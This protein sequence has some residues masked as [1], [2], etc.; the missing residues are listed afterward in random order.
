MSIMSNSS[1]PSFLVNVDFC[2]TCHGTCKGCLLT[3]S[4]RKATEAFL[5]PEQIIQSFQTLKGLMPDA[6][7]AQY[8]ALA[9]GR[10]NTLALS[11]DTWQ[12]MH[13]MATAFQELFSPQKLTVECSTGLIGKIQPLIDIAKRRVDDWGDG[14]RFVVAA[15]S[16][17]YS[18]PYWDNVDAF[19][20]ALM[21]HR[22][23]NTTEESGDVLVLNLVADRLPPVEHLVKRLKQYP[24]PVNIAWLPLSPESTPEMHLASHDW[25]NAFHEAMATGGWDSNFSRFFAERFS[26]TP[27][28]MDALDYLTVNLSR[29]WWVEKD[30]SLRP[31]LF[32]PMGDVDFRRFEEKLGIPPLPQD[33]VRIFRALQRR[34][35]C[36]TCDLQAKCLQ[37]GVALH[38]LAS[39]ST[40]RCPIGVA[41]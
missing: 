39:P 1:W 28:T 7:H 8:A 21:E 40:L 3:E 38:A 24:F 16:D 18:Q 15:N 19:F 26:S 29:F 35:P 6:A 22:G 9:L 11:D 17:L 10:G 41:T 2:G 36:N 37:T 5:S 12:G 27:D 23:G 25:L 13:R 4:E 34:T 30:G 20:E 33:P 14:L 32:T 31:G